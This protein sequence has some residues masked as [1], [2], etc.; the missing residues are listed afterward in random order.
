MVK[1]LV[2]DVSLVTALEASTAV[3]SLENVKNVAG[4]VTVLVLARLASKNY[5]LRLSF[6]NFFTLQEKEMR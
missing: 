1:K 2:I 6:G 5:K 4:T 3:A